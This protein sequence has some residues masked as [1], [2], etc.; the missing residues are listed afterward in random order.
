MTTASPVRARCVHPAWFVAAVA[1]V[2][3]I[4][5]A[6]FRAAPSVLMVPLEVLLLRDR[7]Q[8]LGVLP[9]G[10]DPSDPPEPVLPGR[11][12]ARRA[13][14]GLVTAARTR[15]F[16]ALFA[17]FAICGA[18][19]NGLIGT[20]FVPAAHDHGMA[21][22]TLR[23]AG[24]PL[25]LQRRRLAVR[26]RGTHRWFHG[27]AVLSGGRGARQRRP[28]ARVAWTVWWKVLRRN[29]R[30]GSSRSG[31]RNQG[32]PS[33]ITITQASPGRSVSSG[34]AWIWVW[35][36]WQSSARLSRV[37][38]PP[39]DHQMTWCASHSDGGVVHPGQVHPRSRAARAVCW[40][41]V[42]SLPVV[43]I[44]STRPVL[45]RTTRSMTASQAIRVS[46]PLAD[47]VAAGR[48][49]G[50][51]TLG[52]GELIRG[53]DDHDPRDRPCRTLPGDRRV[54]IGRLLCGGA[55]A[56]ELG[57]GVG[58]HPEGVDATLTTRPQIR[59]AA[60]GAI[61]AAGGTVGLDEVVQDRRE[62]QPGALVELAAEQDHPGLVGR[63]RQVPPVQG[64]LVVP[65]RRGPG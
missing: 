51:G 54:L 55:E 35:W 24:R 12:A 45:S 29:R 27:G 44:A 47:Q 60:V 40:A 65:V 14:Q 33:R 8:D 1:F 43:S 5:A 48:A 42:A 31:G 2:A 34:W 50:T 4:G 28:V 17:G 53:R 11:G 6:G 15:T 49:R 26:P 41:A 36:R 23:R 63:H 39:R 7:P 62:L 16:W 59:L 56:E 61:R 22:T 13:V 52:A 19:T 32:I 10:A 64:V 3:L 38:G 25:G 57:G 21:Q 37:V 18:T 20:H 46:A 9:Y 58:H 30:S